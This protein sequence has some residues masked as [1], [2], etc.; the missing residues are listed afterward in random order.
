MSYEI[1]KG[2][3]E[4]LDGPR[5]EFLIYKGRTFQYSRPGKEGHIFRG[6]DGTGS[7]NV[8]YKVEEIDCNGKP[9]EKN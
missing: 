3:I 8:I 6:I 2:F 5:P 4:S 9:K 7:I 1:R